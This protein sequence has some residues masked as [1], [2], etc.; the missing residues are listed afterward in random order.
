MISWHTVVRPIVVVHLPL[1]V[2]EENEAFSEE[3]MPSV[4]I[5]LFW[6]TYTIPKK[7]FP[8]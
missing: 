7:A 2:S 1:F 3:S 4:N 6:W 5:Q 8:E